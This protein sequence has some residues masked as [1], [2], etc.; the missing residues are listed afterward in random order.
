MWTMWRMRD[1]AQRGVGVLQKGETYA[2]K[3]AAT[4]F[5][6]YSSISFLARGHTGRMIN[7]VSIQMASPPESMQ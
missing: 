7:A 1:V 2:E 4:M 5:A 3:N 6:V